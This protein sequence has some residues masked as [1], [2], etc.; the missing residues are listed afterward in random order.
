MVGRVQEALVMLQQAAALNSMEL[1]I[2]TKS[3]MKTKKMLTRMLLHQQ[4]LLNVQMMIMTAAH[5][6]V[7]C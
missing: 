5:L 7:V 1:K 6:E 2:K 3:R 4:L